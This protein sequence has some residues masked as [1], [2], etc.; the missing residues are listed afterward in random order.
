M[1]KYLK[2]LVPYRWFILLIFTLPFLILGICTVD[3]WN[4]YIYSAVVLI[5]TIILDLT[6]GIGREVNDFRLNILGILWLSL[7]IK[8]MVRYI[9]ALQ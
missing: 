9:N 5:T 8:I 2:T 4:Y 1:K 3:I 7:L 6:I